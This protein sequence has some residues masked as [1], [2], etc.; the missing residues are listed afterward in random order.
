M[1]QL[2]CCACQLL[3]SPRLDLPPPAL[4]NA[5]LVGEDRMER[6]SSPGATDDQGRYQCPEKIDFISTIQ[7]IGA[8]YG[9]A[10]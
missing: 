9:S 8:H 3:S 1:D 10:L 5:T 6:T 2:G 7:S 4:V